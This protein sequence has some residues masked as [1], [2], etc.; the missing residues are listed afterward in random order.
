MCQTFEWPLLSIPCSVVMEI[1]ISS[2]HTIFSIFNPFLLNGCMPSF[3]VVSMSKMWLNLKRTSVFFKKRGSFVRDVHCNANAAVFK[4]WRC[5]K[6]AGRIR[7]ELLHFPS[8]LWCWFKS[9]NVHVFG[10]FIHPSIAVL[11]RDSYAL[12]LLVVKTSCSHKENVEHTW[13]VN[14]EQICCLP[15]S[16]LS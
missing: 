11:L 12:P 9:D 2:L 7:M 3:C 16:K 5:K 6:D 8:S 4:R 1:I 14:F 15:I 13:W 10:T